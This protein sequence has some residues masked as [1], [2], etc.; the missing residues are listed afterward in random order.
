MSGNRKGSISLTALIVVGVFIVALMIFGTLVGK[1]PLINSLVQIK[2]EAVL[3]LES[4]EGGSASYAFLQTKA[5]NRSFMESFSVLASDADEETKDAIRNSMETTLV[6]ISRVAGKN[7]YI[8][9]TDSSGGIIFEKSTGT[10]PSLMNYAGS[11]NLDLKWPA[12][13]EVI[14]S[15]FGWREFSGS[16]DFHG[17]IDIRG[18]DGIDPIYSATDGKVVKVEEDPEVN[19]AGKYVFIDY[20]SPNS[21]ITYRFLYGHMHTILVKEGQSVRKGE[22]IGIIGSTAPKRRPVT[23]PH[24][25]FEMRI[26]MNGDG[27][28]TSDLESIPVC[29]YFGNP[30]GCLDQCTDYYDKNKCGTVGIYAYSGIGIERGLADI[31]LVNGERGRME[32]II[33]G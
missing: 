13:S 7:Y 33:W 26:D 8:K 23:G 4:I 11:E 10:P 1:I 22:K 9:V 25:H 30:E 18:R 31:P 21:G 29:P 14:T 12:E 27:E 19:Y 32:L 2:G 3:H 17:G 28:F 6:G 24:L 5:G 20:T 15:G 16:S